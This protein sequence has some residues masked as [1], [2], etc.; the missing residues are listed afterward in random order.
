ME[1][2][3]ENLR[4]WVAAL[5]SGEYKQGKGTLAHRSPGSG[6]SSPVQYCC[7]GVAC[8]LAKAAGV[9]RSEKMPYGDTV[10]VSVKNPG[11]TGADVLPL[12]VA[13]WLGIS[14]EDDPYAHNPYFTDGK[15]N[16]FT[17]SYWNDEMEYDFDGIADL[18]ENTYKLRD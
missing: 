4:A 6:D 10:Y 18:I 3:K 15:D 17:A 2:N 11:D 16:T 14:T 8:E 5:R 13:R 1:R 7:L 12:D 9:V